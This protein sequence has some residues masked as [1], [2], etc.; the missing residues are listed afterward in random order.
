MLNSHSEKYLNDYLRSIEKKCTQGSGY[1]QNFDAYF[2]IAMNIFEKKFVL[3]DALKREEKV[4]LAIS[5]EIF[6]MLRNI[7]NKQ[8]DATIYALITLSASYV[9]DRLQDREGVQTFVLPLYVTANVKAEI[10]SMQNLKQIFGLP[11]NENI[12]DWT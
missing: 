2:K 10:R 7:E 6:Q 11:R 8:Y 4:I 5:Q 9:C 3:E 1:R 12:K